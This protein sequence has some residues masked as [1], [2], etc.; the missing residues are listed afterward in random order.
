MKMKRYGKILLV[1][2]FI[3]FFAIGL[4][5][6][7]HLHKTFIDVFKLSTDQ[8]LSDLLKHNSPCEQIKDCGLIE[9]D[10]LIRRYITNRTWLI[11]KISNPFFTHSAMYLGRDKI[12]EATGYEDNSGDEIRISNLSQSDWLDE[13]IKAWVVIRAKNISNKIDKIKE[14]LEIIALD[15]EYRFGLP[16]KDHKRF[17]CS[18]LILNPLVREGVVAPINEPA[19]ITPDYLFWLAINDPREFEIIGYYINYQTE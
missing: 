13:P 17:S 1:L 7:S 18:D 4:Y 5:L 11:D 14:D 16:K 8:V 2:F 12:I 6:T 3:T 10:I 19:I 15:P 9:G